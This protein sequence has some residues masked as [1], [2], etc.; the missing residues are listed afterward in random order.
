MKVQNKLALNRKSCWRSPPHP[1]P[2]HYWE[3]SVKDTHECQHTSTILTRGRLQTTSHSWVNLICLSSPH[4]SLMSSNW[5]SLHL[6][7]YYLLEHLKQTVRVG[8]GVYFLLSSPPM[9][10]WTLSPPSLVFG[11]NVWTQAS[12]WDNLNGCWALW[13]PRQV[14]VLEEDK[15]RHWDTELAKIKGTFTCFSGALISISLVFTGL[16][17]HLWIENKRSARKQRITAL[18]DRGFGLGGWIVKDSQ[19]ELR[20]PEIIIFIHNNRQVMTIL[21]II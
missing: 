8:W 6:W 19:M 5:A 21:S 2:T 7:T 13:R 10:P 9:F 4:S 14:R 18:F 12:E 1:P 15:S 3:S 11:A 20:G 17:R 16:Y